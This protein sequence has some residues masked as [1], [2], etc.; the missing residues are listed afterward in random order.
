MPGRE[1]SSRPETRLT[2]FALSHCVLFPISKLSSPGIAS[3]MH[4]PSHVCT[5]WDRR[6]TSGSVFMRGLLL[7]GRRAGG[8]AEVAGRIRIDQLLGALPLFPS[9][10]LLFYLFSSFGLL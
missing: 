8:R 10:Q 4:A 1:S 2:S 5:A 6:R 7:E 3:K 9:Q